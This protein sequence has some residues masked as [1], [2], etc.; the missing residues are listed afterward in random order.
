[1]ITKKLF[2]VFI[3]LLLLQLSL[4]AESIPELQA[5]FSYTGT[6]LG[7]LAS[8]TD[9][10]TISEGSID[11]WHYDFGDGNESSIQNPNHSYLLSGSYDVCLIIT[12]GIYSDTVKKTIE[13][14]DNPVVSLSTDGPMTFCDGKS[15][16]L[17]VQENTLY[18]YQW[19]A[20]DTPIEGATTNS[21][22]AKSTGNYKVTVENENGC[23]SETQA[24]N[25]VVLPA[26]PSP[27]ITISGTTTFCEGDSITLAVY[28]NP[29]I[30]YQWK[31]NGG[32][33][34]INTNS[35]TAKV[36]GTYSLHLSNAEGCTS[37]SVNSVNVSVYANPTVNVSIDGPRLFCEGDAVTF[38]VERNESYTY[39]WMDSDGI[40]TGA[41]ENS[42]QATETGSYFLNVTN[43]GQCV[44]NTS[45]IEITVIPYP[46]MPI[47]V[48]ENYESN[49]CPHDDPVTLRFSNFES[50]VSYQ[51]ER[52]GIA[53]NA[54]IGTYIIGYLNEGDYR[55]RASRNG[56]DIK[57]EPL[58]IQYAEFLEKPTIEASESSGWLLVCNNE[59]ASIYKW[60]YEGSLIP[61]SNDYIYEAGQN[62]G[63]YEVA[64]S[65]QGICFSLSDPI[66]IPLTTGIQ[67]TLQLNANIYP[68]PTKDYL[69]IEIDN[70][71][72]GDLFIIIYNEVG[73]EVE[74]HAYIKEST[75]FN[76]QI[77]L[78]DQPSAVYLIKVMLKDWKASRR[79]VVE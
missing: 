11:T 50:D 79:L 4:L 39:Q 41:T 62:L 66:Y 38:S 6:C 28:N 23:I 58:I 20:S 51:W 44:I 8:F 31:L 54:E 32:A 40:I 68:N 1:M 36:S 74:S 27:T 78:S 21:Y 55:V 48:S 9:A 53:M 47:L 2:F 16:Q 52:N 71:L 29:D 15:V 42:F 37:S 19:M 46:E 5:E 61:N 43:E 24:V 30:I 63:M 33:L 7:E 76:T 64:I 72:T 13:I 67:E 65:E 22:A 77:D 59:S 45:P 75:H 14:F 49:G 3:S 17:S 56:C 69:N 73:Q 34:G 35:Y 70:P 10:S 25:V 26:P 18:T 57:S 60:Y 12:S